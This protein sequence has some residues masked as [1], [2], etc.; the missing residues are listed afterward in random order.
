[1]TN[2]SVYPCS[3]ELARYMVKRY[4]YADRNPSISRCFSLLEGNRIVGTCVFSVPASYTLC[5]GLCG[6][7]YK[8]HV[9]ELSRLVILTTRINAGSWFVSRCLK[10]LGDKIIV[11]YADPNDH[12]GHVGI[13]YQ[14]L[15]FLYTGRGEA[16][17]AWVHPH[18]GE[19]VS[20]TRRWI[21]RKA[22]A[23]GLHWQELKK[24]KQQGKHRYVTFV[25]NK[26]FVKRVRKLLRYPVLPYP[27]G[28]TCRHEI[29]RSGDAD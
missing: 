2:L 12:V 19:V 24:R 21:D 10:Q 5:E 6:E 9:L 14:A 16:E 23:I 8:K 11:S 7:E 13:L 25:G 4:H 26:R 28:S 17:P 22:R 18:T 1:M 27:K 29:D 20:Y 15:N 3:K